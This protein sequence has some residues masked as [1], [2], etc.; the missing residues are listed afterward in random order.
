MNSD[1]TGGLLFGTGG[2]P[3]SAQSRSTEAGIERIAELGLGCME[4]E[5]VQGVRMSPQAAV[6][7]GELAARKNVVLTAHGPYF[8]NLNAVEPQKV[9]M[10]KERILQTA[11]T[12]ALFGARSITFH[13]AFYLKSTPEETYATV[14]KHLQQV[15]NILQKEGNKVTISPEVTGK[16]SQFGTIEE[17]LQLSS[18]IEGVLPCIDFSHWHA[19][20]GKANSYQEFL[21]ILDQ[22]ERKLG[23]QALDNMHIHISG[24]AYGNKGE[25]KHLMLP[26]SDFQYAELLKALK[27]RKAKGVIICESVPYLEQDAL[28]LQQTYR[29]LS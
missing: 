15:V 13:A 17:I 14:K 28:L 20:T 16:P 3:V 11:R 9:H 1:E 23:R 5:F 22:V 18:E 8:I 2:V 25:I 24:I 26:D 7:V 10:S 4:V 6:S 27:E 21:D 29:E 12:A 19:R